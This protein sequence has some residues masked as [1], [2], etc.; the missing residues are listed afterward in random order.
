MNWIIKITLTKE[1]K[2]AKPDVII[3]AGDYYQKLDLVA[4][5]LTLKE[6]G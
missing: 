2:I 5:S 1:L 4:N 6:T 3:V